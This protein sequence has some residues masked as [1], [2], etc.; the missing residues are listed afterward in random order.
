MKI[1][2]PKKQE[3]ADFSSAMQSKTGSQTPKSFHNHN[4]KLCR[5]LDGIIPLWEV[6][7]LLGLLLCLQLGFGW[8]E[9]TTDG[10]SET[11]AEIEWEMLLL[12]V[13]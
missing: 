9:A 11:W 7:L 6:C 4:P 5:G 3:G 12:C 2:P 1:H 13:E 10:T 8:C